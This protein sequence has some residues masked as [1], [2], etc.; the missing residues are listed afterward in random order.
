MC[1][2][3]QVMYPE[4][5]E[6]MSETE[7]YYRRAL[8][9]LMYSPKIGGVI[10]NGAE[11]SEESLSWGSGEERFFAALRMTGKTQFLTAQSIARGLCIYACFDIVFL[12][13]FVLFVV[14]SWFENRKA[15]GTGLVV[16]GAFLLDI[17]HMIGAAQL[18]VNIL[19]N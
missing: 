17:L 15:P 14:V 2:Q 3:I 18:S 16:P 10:L 19:C 11:R 1:L 6:E 4:L 12:L 8:T 5:R 13:S 9:A 7:I